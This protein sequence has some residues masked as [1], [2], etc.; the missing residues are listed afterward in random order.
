MKSEPFNLTG[1]RGCVRVPGN[2]KQKNLNICTL[3]L[4]FAKNLLNVYVDFARCRIGDNLQPIPPELLRELMRLCGISRATLTSDSAGS[5]K[6]MEAA[7][8]AKSDSDSKASK[9]L[10]RGQGGEEKKEDDAET[11]KN[12]IKNILNKKKKKSPDFFVPSEVNNPWEKD[13]KRYVQYA[14]LKVPGSRR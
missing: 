7:L 2:S 9:L 8:K 5:M 11:K 14:K 1:A 4:S 10:N 13:R 12:L 3:S 6:K